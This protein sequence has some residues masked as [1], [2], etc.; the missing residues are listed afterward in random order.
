MIRKATIKDMYQVTLLSR[1]SGLLPDTKEDFDTTVEFLSSPN[2]FCALAIRGKKVDGLVRCFV[3][4]GTCVMETLFVAPLMR[5]KGIAKDLFLSA[6]SFAKANKC[7]KI[8]IVAPSDVEIKG[9]N[10]LSKTWTK[11]V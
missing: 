4:Q 7:T 11:E 10:L 2:T 1:E 9:F 8:N 3:K 6:E 5:K